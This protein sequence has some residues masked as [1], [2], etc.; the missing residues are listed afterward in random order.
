MKSIYKFGSLFVFGMKLQL[1]FFLKMLKGGVI[2]GIFPAI[3]TLYRILSFS[4]EEKTLQ[5]IHIKEELDNVSKKEFMQVNIFG[6]LSMLMI[7]LLGMNFYISENFIKIPAFHFLTILMLVL[8]IGT[9]LYL[10]PILAKYELPMKQYILQAFI[11]NI[12]SIFDSIAIFIGIFIALVF[13]LLPPIGFFAG[14]PLILL[15][16]VWFTKSSMKRLET[17]IYK[18]TI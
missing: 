9:S 4:V 14:I 3:L 12:I 17:V 10:L 6:W 8:V 5:I 15:P 18:N 13:C 11:L 2:F 7:F 16:Y 1:I